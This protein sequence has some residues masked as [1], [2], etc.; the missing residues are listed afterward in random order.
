MKAF[1]AGRARLQDY[2]A[3]LAIVE[4]GNLTQA[5]AR[6]R[7]SL[8]SISRSLSALEAQ[9]GVVLI[10]RTTR[11]AQ[12]TEA[13]LAFERRVGAAFREIALAEAELGDAL[14][15]LSGTLRLAG[16]A[17]FISHYVIPAIRDFSHQHPAVKF[18][19]R[20][21]E[22]F[23]EPVRHG[24]DLMIRI[25]HLPASPMKS[26]KIATL[27]RVA[28]ASTSYIAERGRPENPASLARHACIVR[29]SAQDARA[30][31]FHARDGSAVRVPVQ[32]SFES[33]NAYVTMHA[34][35]SGL[36]VAIVPFY[37]AREAVAAGLAQIVLDDFTLE[38][39]TAHAIWPSGSRLP[40]RV[41]R[42]V[43]L[44]V[45]RLKKEAI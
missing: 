27:R 20:I 33:D 16:S 32:G 31:T 5:A 24:V 8:Q 22:E 37:H 40:S 6:L 19:L 12:P 9:V 34:V 36:G 45:Q 10:R 17:Y 30:W 2:E 15:T 28:I 3:F 1:P 7:R 38:P 13:G 21:S 39:T 29:A 23:T 43:D 44:L 35:L 41:R 26:R 4:T 11:V 14:E 42:F 18:D 25:G